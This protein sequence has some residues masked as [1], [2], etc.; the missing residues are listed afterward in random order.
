[1]KGIGTAVVMG[2]AAA[3][4]SLATNAAQARPYGYDAPARAYTGDPAYGA[5]AY[6]RGYAAYGYAP[7][8]RTYDSRIKSVPRH[9]D[10]GAG[11]NS[12]TVAPWQD[13]KNQGRDY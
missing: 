1:M 4:G 12:N 11:F 6:E 7:R 2:L 13:W 8:Y 9:Y 3:V 10:P 5:Y